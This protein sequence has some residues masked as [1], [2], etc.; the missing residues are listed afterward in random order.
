MAGAERRLLAKDGAEFHASIRDNGYNQV[1]LVMQV[2]LGDQH[3]PEQI[4]RVTDRA[5]ARKIAN[6]FAK[7]QGFDKVIWTEC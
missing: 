3:E 6:R 5:T 1:V 4:Q 7:E 2:C